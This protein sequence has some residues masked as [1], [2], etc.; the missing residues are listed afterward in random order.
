M[1]HTANIN[2]LTVLKVLERV[3]I[4]RNVSSGLRVFQMS[5][6]NTIFLFH[7]GAFNSF[8]SLLFLTLS[9]PSLFR[10]A[11]KDTDGFLGGTSLCVVQ[12]R[13]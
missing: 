6:P 13:R 1:M 8:F 9:S 5:K 2:E 3:E 11:I 4:S 10:D 7:L 12:G